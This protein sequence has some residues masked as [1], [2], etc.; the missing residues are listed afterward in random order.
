MNRDQV[1]AIITAIIYASYVIAHSEKGLSNFEGA[2]IM[3]KKI[4]DNFTDL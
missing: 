1:E 4:T 3:A 2:K